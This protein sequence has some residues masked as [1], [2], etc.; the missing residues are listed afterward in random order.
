[1]GE[2]KHIDRLFQERFKDFEVT[3]DTDIWNRIQDELG[4]KK[5]RRVIP[6][7]MQLGGIAAAVALLFL[8]GYNLLSNGSDTNTI[9]NQIVDENTEENNSPTLIENNN[10]KQNLETVTNN[11]VANEDTNKVDVDASTNDQKITTKNSVT[12]QAKTPVVLNKNKWRNVVASQEKK[13]ETPIHKKTNLIDTNVKLNTNNGVIA[14]NTATTKNNEKDENKIPAVI[15]DGAQLKNKDASTAVVIANKENPESDKINP[16]I[17]SSIDLKDNVVVTKVDAKNEDASVKENKE[18]DN[19]PSLFD[20]INKEEKN[21]EVATAETID[22]KWSVNPMV[23]PVYYNTIGEG[24]PIHSQFKDNN[25]SGNI[26]VSYG[27]GVAYQ[28]S[29]RLSVRSGVNVVNLGYDTEEIAFTASLD[30]GNLATISYN[31]N[32]SRLDVKDKT[33]SN[34]SDFSSDVPND[35]NTF[36]GA[37]ETAG[38][39]SQ[40]FGYVEVPL[41]LKYRLLDKKLGVNIIGGLSSL[42]LT[43]NS[44]SLVSQDNLIT[45][46]GEANNVNNTSFTTNIGLGIDY[47]LSKNLQLNLEPIFKYQLNAFNR[48]AGDFQPFYMGVYTGVSFKF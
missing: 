20:A 27:V 28:V 46:V 42:F 7:W 1:M 40:Q 11:A 48:E 10:N 41:E 35:V 45:D 30:G 43:D 18:E 12:N 8:L 37:A 31:S 22:R 25:K 36:R 6:F 2:K 3:P 26:N 13:A 24:S 39:M 9:E 19:K 17:N 34:T 33:S 47:A 32:T 29:K 23:A 38:I 14:N 21:T 5:K 16:N 15:R 4:H 44:I